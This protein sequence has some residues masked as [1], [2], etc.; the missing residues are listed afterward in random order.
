MKAASRRTIKGSSDML[1]RQRWLLKYIIQWINFS[2]WIDDKEFHY[3]WEHILQRMEG[4]SQPGDLDEP[5]YAKYLRESIFIIR[6]GLLTAEWR[7][8]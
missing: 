3:F 2:A 7:S 1:L 8:A 6:N 5:H 4:D